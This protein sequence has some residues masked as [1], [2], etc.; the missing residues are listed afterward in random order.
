MRDATFYGVHACR[1][2]FE[3]RPED[4]RRAF[5]LEEMTREFGDML[6]ELAKQKRPYRI[7]EEDELATVA[8]TR[9]HEGVCVIAAPTPELET[10]ALLAR[11]DQEAGPARV[12]FLDGVENPHNVGA[13]LRSA[14]HFGALALAGLADEL[15]AIAGASA[16]VAQGAAEHVPVVRWTQPRRGLDAL[17]ARGFARVATVVE[18]GDDLFTAS[19][20]ERCVLL[21]GS[22]HAGLGASARAIADL[23][24]TIP[25][26]GAV[27]SLN[28]AA[29]AAVLLAEHWRRYPG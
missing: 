1:A 16:R 13:L 9:H 26:T 22:E 2:L 4:V 6:R 11:L 28:A 8:G 24:V 3:R 15:P 20:P 12:L 5:V 19:L 23:R 10:D 14:A 27:E 25:G 29:A 18:G 21:I 17:R 7:V